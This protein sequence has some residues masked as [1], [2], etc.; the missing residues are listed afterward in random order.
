MEVRSSD[1]RIARSTTRY[2]REAALITKVYVRFAYEGFVFEETYTPEPPVQSLRFPLTPGASWKGSWEDS[3]SGDYEVQVFERESLEVGG[4]SV[5][6]YRIQTFTD[7]RGQFQGRSKIETWIDPATK[8]I[9]KTRG[10]LNVTSAFGRYSTSFG[11]Q[12]RS[13]PG[14]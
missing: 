5:Q 8:A 14:Y 13:G 6:A 1:N 10:V 7:F 4:R 9:V 2:S 3:T 12:L 11:T